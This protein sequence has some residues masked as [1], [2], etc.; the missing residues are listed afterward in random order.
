MDCGMRIKVV[1]KLYSWK[2]EVFCLGIGYQKDIACKFC[3]GINRAFTC[4]KRPDIVD[5]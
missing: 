2:A 1:G 5:F 4:C 3:S